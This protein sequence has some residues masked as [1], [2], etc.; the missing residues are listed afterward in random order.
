MYKSGK[1]E[2]EKVEKRVNKASK[3]KDLRD[4][5]K[6]VFEVVG[7]NPLYCPKMFYTPSGK[8]EKYIS[9]FPSELQQGRD[10]YTEMVDRDYNSEDPSRTL[11]RWDYNM[12]WETDYEMTDSQPPR[13]LIPVSE[14][15][16]VNTFTSREPQPNPSKKD[17]VTTL[18][19]NQEADL[20]EDC[21]LE[22]ITLRDI[23]AL[24]SWQPVSNK[25]FL[26]DLIKSV[27]KR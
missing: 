20:L 7:G 11:Y 5:H 1:M 10:I 26:N 27:P 14:L 16:K 13:Y 9:F 6:P 8:S 2:T 24:I 15:K 12:F 18:F 3:I 4:Y 21:P 23:A 17:K 22:K 19:S 25:K